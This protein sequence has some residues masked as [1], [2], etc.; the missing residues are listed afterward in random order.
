MLEIQQQGHPRVRLT[1]ADLDK[2]V[3]ALLSSCVRGSRG[4]D[5]FRRV[6]PPGPERSRT[7]PASNGVE[8]AAA[9]SVLSQT[10]A[11]LNSGSWS[12]DADTYAA[13]TPSYGPGGGPH[14]A[15]RAPEPGSR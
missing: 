8:I 3:L 2:Q 5:R 4:A 15:D 7:T 11:L 13:K 6:L 12:V 10:D 14:L 9:V 1:E